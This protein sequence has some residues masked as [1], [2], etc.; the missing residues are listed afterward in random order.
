M[1]IEII[2][3]DMERVYRQIAITDDHYTMLLKSRQT[4]MQ[5]IR[6]IVRV[7]MAKKHNSNHKTIGIAE[8]IITG[9]VVHRTTVWH[10]D[11]VYTDYIVD[12]HPNT[13]AM[14]MKIVYRGHK[15]NQRL[16]EIIKAATCQ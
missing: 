5:I 9:K 4:E 13:V 6:H 14:V 12:K 11:K 16:R 1:M 3:K 10:S 8:G 2:K 15:G 7:L